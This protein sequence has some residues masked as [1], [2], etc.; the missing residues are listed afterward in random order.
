MPY[1]QLELQLRDGAAVHWS[2]LKIAINM[3]RRHLLIRARSASGPFEPKETAAVR[4]D[5]P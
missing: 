1:A 4:S 5:G 3:G 2:G